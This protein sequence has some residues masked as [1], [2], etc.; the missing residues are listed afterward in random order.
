MSCSCVRT[1]MSKNRL[2]GCLLFIALLLPSASAR[3][4]RSA[5]WRGH[6]ITQKTYVFGT[7]TDAGN[8]SAHLNMGYGHG[9]KVG[10]QLLVLRRVGEEVIPVAAVT[11]RSLNGEKATLDLEG[12][13]QVADGDVA[14][15]RAAQLNLWTDRDRQEDLLLQRTIRRENSNRWDSLDVSPQLVNEV[16]RD[17]DQR[18]NAHKNSVSESYL[19]I[20][21][22][23]ERLTKSPSGVVSGRLHVD[24]DDP[25]KSVP[26][27]ELDDDRLMSLN[28][29]IQATASEE[30]MIQ[31]LSTDRL[32]QLPLSSTQKEVDAQTA[33]LLRRTLIAWSKKIL[34]PIPA[35]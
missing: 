30:V 24:P 21:A 19:A 18:R 14:M 32:V 9:L 26:Q 15:I 22:E 1:T 16:A 20:R 29:L 23:R 13:F 12:P 2:T 27:E 33:V 10:H 8:H 7:I 11:V 4:E 3:A 25:S 28:R 17:D 34:S 35:N 31:R 5:V 6:R